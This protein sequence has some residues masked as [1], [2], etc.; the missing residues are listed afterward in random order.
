MTIVCRQTILMKYHALFLIFE[1]KWQ[2]LKL[3]SAANYRWC[4][5]VSIHQPFVFGRISNQIDTIS[6]G[7]PIFILIGHK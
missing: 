6:V 7:K 4:F 3:P 2:Y 5:R 1:K